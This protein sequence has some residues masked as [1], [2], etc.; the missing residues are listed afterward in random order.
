[1]T[2][3]TLAPADDAEIIGTPAFPYV[4]EITVIVSCTGCANEAIVT[5][6]P[7]FNVRDAAR[8]LLAATRC[9]AGTPDAPYCIPGA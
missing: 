5:E 9:P 1:M 4:S 6:H 2:Y 8:A 7:A 3:A